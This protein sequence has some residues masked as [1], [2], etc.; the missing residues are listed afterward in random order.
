PLYQTRSTP[1]VLIEVAAKLKT[2]IAMPWKTYDEAIKA[3]FD[4]IDPNAWDDVAKQGGHWAPGTPPGAAL[5]PAPAPS[6]QHPAP[7]TRAV[8]FEPPLFDGDVAAYPYYF[9][10]YPSQAFGDGSTAHLPWLQEMP[11]PMTSA[12]WSSW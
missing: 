5:H 4:K 2:P 1:D 8:A 7:D 12:M 11:D 6:T 9:Q 10:P 3:G